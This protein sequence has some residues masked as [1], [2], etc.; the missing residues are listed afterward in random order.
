MTAYYSEWDPFAAQ[1]TRN[2][3]AAGQITPGVV[4]E[5]SI[6]ELRA[7]DV[8][9][10]ERVHAFSGI[11][12]WDHALELA[13]WSGPVWTGSCPCQS[14]SSAGK[15]RGA[16]DARHLWPEWF[17]LIAACR[18]GVVLG[19]QVA[20]RD[21]V[22]A[23]GKTRRARSGADRAA[24]LDLVSADLESIGYAVGACVLTAGGVGAP[25]VRARL[26]F[27]AIRMGDADED[28]AGRNRG[29][30]H[31]AEAQGLRSRQV[32]G[33]DRDGAVAPG[34]DD[35]WGAVEWVELTDGTTRPVGTGVRA[36][37]PRLPGDLARLGAFGNAVTVEL[38]AT[39]IRAVMGELGMRPVG[40][41]AA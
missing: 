15:R 28:D 17:R 5:R 8:R 24:W 10:V 12:G 41:V 1:W 37:A 11:A 3:I 7:D 6:A 23:V 9:G 35:P 29:D 30:A 16:D 32:D 21:V 33:A 4:D 25:H 36:V 20:S 2:L 13:G 18:P 26:Y 14:W 38:A 39:F 19:E 40:T 22:G 31:R 27:S 34:R